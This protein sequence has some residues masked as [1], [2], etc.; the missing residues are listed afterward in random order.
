MMTP[1]EL[2]GMA[3]Q[4]VPSLSA[5]AALPGEPPSDGPDELGS[6]QDAIHSVAAAMSALA[7][8]QDTQDCAQAL[9]TL[10]KIQTRRMAT[11]AGGP[12]PR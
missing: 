4:G 6:L 9:L 1:P 2:A 5:L 10:T 3:P 11:G 7:D 12:P 8:P